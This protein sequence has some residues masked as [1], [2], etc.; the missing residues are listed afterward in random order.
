MMGTSSKGEVNSSVLRQNILKLHLPFRDKKHDLQA[1]GRLL[2]RGEN[3]TSQHYRLQ[4]MALIDKKIKTALDYNTRRTDRVIYPSPVMH[5]K[6]YEIVDLP[7][8]PFKTKKVAFEV[9]NCMNNLD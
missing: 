2:L 7:Y 6:A 3:N 9:L 1:S 8:L 5:E 4:T